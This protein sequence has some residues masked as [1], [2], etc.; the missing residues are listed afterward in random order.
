MTR[1]TFNLQLSTFNRAKFVDGCW[2]G[3]GP[4][5]EESVSALTPSEVA[6]AGARLEWS[7]KV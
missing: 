3:V 1:R 4:R 6:F 5:S 7:E 2:K